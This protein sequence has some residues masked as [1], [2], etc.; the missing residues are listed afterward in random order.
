MLQKLYESR[1]KANEESGFTL[2]ELLIVIVV[3]AI[4]AAIV[5]F[6]LSGVTS[7]SAASSLVKAAARPRRFA[8]MAACP[9]RPP[10]TVHSSECCS[11]AAIRQAAAC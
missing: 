7:Q 5:I 1:T 9:R 8:V 2:I 3:L 6:G 4:L 10:I 11:I